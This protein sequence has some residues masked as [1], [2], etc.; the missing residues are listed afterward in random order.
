MTDSPNPQNFELKKKVK[1]MENMFDV[2][3]KIDSNCHL[4]ILCISEIGVSFL[5][6]KFNIKKSNLEFDLF[7]NLIKEEENWQLGGDFNK[8][9][10]N[11]TIFKIIKLKLN[12]V[13]TIENSEKII[14][15]W[16]KKVY[17]LSKEIASIKENKNIDKND[18]KVIPLN[19]SNGWKNYGS[20]Y[21][22]GRIIKK[23]NEITLSGLIAGTNFS[24]VG[25]LPKDCR[26]KERLIF[27]LNHHSSIMRYDILANGNI[28]YVT[29]SNS[30]NWISLDGI[31]FFS[32]I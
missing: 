22:P 27:S 2:I 32:G 17:D 3:F 11:I 29:G 19:F 8:N 30:Y 23:G 13:N 18:I 25:V 21:S 1:Y 16:C 15:Y 12:I 26:P 5:S 7:T 9:E 14:Q 4:E 20:G 6:E 31:H 10:L 28:E 24:V